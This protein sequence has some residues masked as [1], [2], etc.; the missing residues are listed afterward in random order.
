MKK[1]KSLICLVTFVPTL[2]MASGY[3]DV[4]A[5]DWTRDATLTHGSNRAD[6]YQVGPQRLKELQTKGYIHALKYPINV[7]G[8]LIPFEPLEFF[9]E[10]DHTNPLRKLIRKI[11]GKALPF[12]SMEEMYKWL[13][14]N[15]FNDENATGIYKIPYPEGEKPDYYMGASILDTPQGKA[16]TFSCATCHSQHLFGKTVMGLT[17]K[18]PRANMFFTLAKKT[19]PFIPSHIFKAA[20]RATEDER[21]M[22]RK[23]KYNLFAIGAVEPQVLGLDTSLPQVALSLSR[24]KTDE[25]ASKSRFYERFP[26]K[27]K[28]E[29]F[30]A[31]SK[32]ATWWNLKYKT[33]WLADGSIVEGNPIFTNFLWNEIGRGT[34]LVELQDWLE[35]NMD[36]VQDLTAAV[37]ATEAPKWTDFFPADSIDIEKAKRGE[38][39]FNDTCK[40]C[41]GTYQKGWSLTQGPGLTLEEQIKTV[42]VLYHEKT[43]VKDVGTDPQRWQGTHA[44]ADALN[45]LKVSKWMK[46]VVEP[47][48]GYVPPPLEGIWARYPYFHNNAVPNLCALFTPPAQR[49]VTF[50]QGPANDPETDFN[51]ECVGYPVGKDIPKE[52]HEE[53]D[54]HFDTRKPGLRNTG[55]YK[56]WLDEEGN[57]KYSWQ[58]KMAVIEYLKT[59]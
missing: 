13:G 21:K 15:P 34:D 30:V 5:P 19:V 47:Q 14:L 3:T 23:T 28:L 51:Q 2:L 54:A 35:K 40:K 37:F 25:L 6:I 16:I 50:F 10:A 7:T 18:R 20:T 59:L 53:K 32:P 56:M 1:I 41:H 38:A 46:T 48:E 26:R 27:N 58:E 31:D 45:N 49:P 8:A 17:N 11:S 57:E 12:Q 9:M 43:P 44:F 29:K 22:F 36:K 24:R 42:Q 55:H 33:R 52:W 39:I 4:Q